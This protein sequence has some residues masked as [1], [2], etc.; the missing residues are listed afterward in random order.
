MKRKVITATVLVLV[1]AGG[2][3][4]YQNRHDIALKMNTDP[5]VMATFEGI[6]LGDTVDEVTAKMGDPLGKIE[7]DGEARYKGTTFAV[8]VVES[9]VAEKYDRFG[10]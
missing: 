9:V 3:A 4:L 6:S 10:S 2:L 1:L 8:K 5:K 7:V